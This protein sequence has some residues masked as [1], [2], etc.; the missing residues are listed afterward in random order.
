MP[1]IHPL[2][3]PTAKMWFHGAAKAP[4]ISALLAKL[5]HGYE[6]Q[7][8]YLGQC[9]RELTSFAPKALGESMRPSIIGSV[10][11]PKNFRVPKPP[12][13]DKPEPVAQPI[14]PAEFTTIKQAR[15]VGIIDAIRPSP[16]AAAP[17]P[18]DY[19][20]RVLNLW[21]AGVPGPDIARI[22]GVQT[23]CIG[24]DVARWRKQGEPRAVVRQPLNHGK[25]RNAGPRKQI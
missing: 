5:G 19:K 2:F 18:D 21:E 17:R 4:T 1:L 6:A 22:F 3:C 20:N 7:D 15:Q 8:F 11:Y 24:R 25:S 16:R 13:E 12:S 14:E 23:I 9:P 10:P